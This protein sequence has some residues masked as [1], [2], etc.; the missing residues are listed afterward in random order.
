MSRNQPVS[1]HEFTIP[2]QML[3]DALT[4]LLRATLGTPAWLDAVDRAHE[5]LSAVCLIPTEKAL[6]PRRVCLNTLHLTPKEQARRDAA[7][8]STPWT[9]AAIAEADALRRR[10]T[11]PK[12]TLWSLHL[13]LKGSLESVLRLPGRP[14][15]RSGS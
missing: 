13:A 1:L 5:T 2:E 12:P 7:P 9:G 6:P 3:W 15:R 11:A 10:G 8:S 4:G 14:G